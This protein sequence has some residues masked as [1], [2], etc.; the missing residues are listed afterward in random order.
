M[1]DNLTSWLYRKYSGVRRWTLGLTG[2]KDQI[3]VIRASGSISRVR[4]PFSTRGTGIIAED[5][6]E[7]IQTVRGTFHLIMFSGGLIFCGLKLKGLYVVMVHK[8]GLSEKVSDILMISGIENIS[9][10]L[11]GWVTYLGVTDVCHGN[12]KKK[13]KSLANIWVKYKWK[14]SCNIHDS[15]G[16]K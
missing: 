13:G 3:A 2:Y 1:T 9:F 16:I 7:K 4:G 12:K 15:I 5:I 10:Q 6:I 11:F 14:L 8:I